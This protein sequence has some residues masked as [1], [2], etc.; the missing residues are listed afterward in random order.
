MV[1]MDTSR[2][3]GMIS[4]FDTETMVKNLVALKQSKVDNVRRDKQYAVWQQ[5]IYRG[6]ISDLK[7]FESQFLDVS[8]TE[9]CFL[10]EGTFNAYKATASSTA[11][12]VD[13]TGEYT[14]DTHTISNITIA[15]KDIWKGSNI[16]SMIG[17]GVNIGAINSGDNTDTLKIILDGK[18][19]IITLDG[20]YGDV[21]A[22]VTD[23]GKKIDEAFGENK[24]TVTN[25]GGELSIDASGHVFQ[26]FDTDIY[27]TTLS[28]AVELNFGA[29]DAG[30]TIS[31]NLDG[32]VKTITLDGGY[33]DA[34]ELINDVQAKIDAE[35]GSGI[36]TVGQFDGKMTIEAPEH[37]LKLSETLKGV[38]TVF[39]MGFMSGDKN[40]LNTSKSLGD[41]NFSNDIFGAETTLSFSINGETFTFDKSSDT[42][43]DM[44]DEVNN[45]DNA[46]VTMYYSQVSN[47]FTLESDEEGVMNQITFQDITGSFFSSGIGIDHGTYTGRT[48]TGLDASFTLDG[49]TTT[50]STNSFT[51]DGINYTLNETTTDTIDISVES[52]ITNLKETVVK[53]V[54]EYN[55]MIDKFND[56]V[57]EERFYDFE[58][59]TD[60][61]KD[62]MS[63]TE[64]EKWEEKAK[65]GILRNDDVL[66]KT[67]R[68]FRYALTSIESDLGISLYDLGITTSN[69]VF[70]GG[71]L[72]IDE[73]K[74]DKALETRSDAVRRLFTDEENGIGAK[75]AEAMD[76]A[77][78]PIGEFKGALLEKAGWEGTSTEQKNILSEKIDDYDDRIEELL[79]DLIDAEN[80]YYAKFAAMEVALQQLNAQSSWLTNQLGQ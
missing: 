26:I 14:A 12:S 7:S 79:E 36:V 5:E 67:M 30:D 76:Y 23:L 64:I 28:E 62:E 34:D 75:M 72:V 63:E 9:T 16:A 53:F 46:N 58:P 77:I 71:Q 50:R 48:Q 35:F 25:S 4:G 44:I 27:N 31:V 38:T 80:R 32:D 6:V 70:D 73:E 78:A 42:V 56:L 61:E 17:S 60:E 55:T 21:D 68:D 19:E 33:A 15:Q 3:T 66:T 41:A 59:L 22:L 51:I 29:I 11:V 74:L 2:I 65:S 24:V 54:D 20:G 40:V 10:L 8:N 1:Y 57:K 43:Q 47:T 69:N 18:S 52:D 49:V 13:T 37:T 45:N 39:A